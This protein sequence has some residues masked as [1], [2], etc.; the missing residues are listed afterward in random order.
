[1]HEVY[2]T[3]I[4]SCET[5]TG[6]QDINNWATL[7]PPH[8]SKLIPSFCTDD[9][10]LTDWSYTTCH[11]SK[12]HDKDKCKQWK[13]RHTLF[14]LKRRF[15]RCTKNVIVR[16]FPVEQSLNS[17][18]I[19]VNINNEITLTFE[20]LVSVH[21]TKAWSKDWSKPTCHSNKDHGKAK[22]KPS[23]QWKQRHT[24]WPVCCSSSSWRSVVR[25]GHSSRASAAHSLRFDCTPAHY[26]DG[27]SG[28]TRNPPSCSHPSPLDRHTLPPDCYCNSPSPRSLQAPPSRDYA[29]CET[30]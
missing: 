18:M 7:T 10:S 5:I 15:H 3:S 4:I 23:K 21:K 25:R 14:I 16:L 1:M 26:C 13:Q 8:S 20:Y 11:S 6:F 28:R 19:V 24:N 9:E 30:S 17:T 29:S 12:S 22:C 2:E 27:R